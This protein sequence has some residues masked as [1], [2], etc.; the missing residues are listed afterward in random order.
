VQLQEQMRG[1]WLASFLMVGVL[2][3]ALIWLQQRYDQ[4]DHRRAIELLGPR[5]DAGWWIGKELEARNRGAP[6][7]CEA[8]IT[9]SLWGQVQ[10]SCPISGEDAYRFQVDLIRKSVAPVDARTAELLSAVEQK[11][12]ART[13]DE[14]P[15]QDGTP[16][17]GL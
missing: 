2:V 8:T 10:V 3:F 7:D 12:R 4:S 9:S 17:G 11:Q 15:P 16:A 5:A 1:K 13:A 6:P 14:R